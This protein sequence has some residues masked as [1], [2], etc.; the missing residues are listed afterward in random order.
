MEDKMEALRKVKDEK[1]LELVKTATKDMEEVVQKIGAAMYQQNAEAQ[2]NAPGA[3]GEKPKDK[4]EEPVEGDFEEVK[5]NKKD[6]SS[7][8]SAKDEDK[9]ENKK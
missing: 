5:E 2:Q 4:K 9:K 3:A 1:D 6:V 8:A 7:E